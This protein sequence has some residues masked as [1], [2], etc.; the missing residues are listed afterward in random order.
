MHPFARSIIAC[1]ALAL[2]FVRANGGAAVRAAASSPDRAPMSL[3]EYANLSGFGTPTFDVRSSNLPDGNGLR[4]PGPDVCTGAQAISGAGQFPFDL[5]NLST[6]GP[7]TNCG[8]I[9]HDYWF[10]WTATCGGN[11]TFD[12]CTSA[13]DTIIAIYECC[14]GDINGDCAVNESD[15]GLL[16][17]SWQVGPGGDVNG[18]GLTNESDLGILL[19]N[20]LC[21]VNT[22]CPV[23][24][25]LEKV[26]SDSGV[27]PGFPTRASVQLSAVAGRTYRVRVG[28]PT[29]ASAGAG[30][31]QITCP[32]APTSCQSADGLN[33][34]TSDGQLFVAAEE[35]RPGQD[36]VVTTLRWWGTAASGPWQVRF[37]SD[38]GGLPGTPISS[39]GTQPG[40]LSVTSTATGGTISPGFPE[41][42]FDSIHAPVPVTANNCVW[43]EIVNQSGVGWFWETGS[44]GDHRAM[45]DGQSG[46]IDGYAIDDAISEDLAMCVDVQTSAASGCA[47]PCVVNCPAGSILE[48]EPCNDSG[49][50][51]TNNG[52]SA[53][54][55]LFETVSCGARICGTLWARSGLRDSDWYLVNLPNAGSIQVS[56]Q[57][58]MPA[59]VAILLPICNPITPASPGSFVNVATCGTG[60]ASTGILS[61]GPYWIAVNTGTTAAGIFDGYACGGTNDYVLTVNC[62]P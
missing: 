28:V 7:I 39:F 6:D 58:E 47:G 24:P 61:P 50:G 1:A 48:G 17:Q 46:V 34:Y 52:C 31:L 16:L 37:L 22:G 26:C 21:D 12:T 43:V 41:F 56:L 44:T 9:E 3:S 18:D 2:L 19:Q 27:C 15:L 35:F 49:A 53:S 38:S 36:G 20:W 25:G 10:R 51:G 23:N 14:P 30:V 57:T 33:A 62:V 13:I 4:G 45:V 32:G 42:Q 59:W 54:P 5:S 40:S 29:G 11:V 60:S 55:A 8:Q